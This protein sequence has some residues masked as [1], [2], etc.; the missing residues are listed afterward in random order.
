MTALFFRYYVDVTKY[1]L[2]F[3]ALY[4]IIRGNLIEGVILFATIGAPISFIIYKY[5]HNIEYYFYMNGGLSK[6]HLQLTTFIINLVFS[7][8]I[9]LIWCIRYR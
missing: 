9:L 5:F 6:K 4:I 1:N 8:L 7:S 3:C 2:F